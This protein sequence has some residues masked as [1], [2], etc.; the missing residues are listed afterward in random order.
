MSFTTGDRFAFRL[1]HRL[2]STEEE[3]TEN[4]KAA[5]RWANSLCGIHVF[6]GRW[7]AASDIGE[8]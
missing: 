1:P 8:G 7:Q 3:H 2:P 6:D 5:E 4:W